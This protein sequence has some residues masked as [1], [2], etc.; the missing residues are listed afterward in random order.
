M[1]ITFLHAITERWR[2]IDPLERH[3]TSQSVGAAW[4]HTPD[5]VVDRRPASKPWTVVRFDR[6]MQGPWPGVHDRS[7]ESAPGAAALRVAR[8]SR[9]RDAAPTSRGASRP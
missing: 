7:T 6:L 2:A 1:D 3:A 9:R 5:G 8:C 4:P